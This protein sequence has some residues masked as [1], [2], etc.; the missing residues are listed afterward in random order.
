MCIKRCSCSGL[1]KNYKGNTYADICPKCKLKNSFVTIPNMFRS[2]TVEKP[3][4]LSIGNATYL[5]TSG[6]GLLNFQGGE[7]EGVYNLILLDTKSKTDRFTFEFLAVSPSGC[8]VV[9]FASFAADVTINTCK[10]CKKK[11][12]ISESMDLSHDKKNPY[13]LT[14]FGN[15][16]RRV[17][18]YPNGR[19]DEEDLINCSY[20][21]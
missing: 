2:L 20:Y 10:C 21:K 11:K 12:K 15:Y 8:R 17:I 5:T 13:D 1:V 4:C 9:L 3:T 18:F 16:A 14:M 19:I 6:T 7:I